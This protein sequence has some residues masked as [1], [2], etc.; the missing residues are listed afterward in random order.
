MSGM[1]IEQ[2]YVGFLGRPASLWELNSWQSADDTPHT[3][4]AV[5]D[6]L[7]QSFE[8]QQ[9]VSQGNA[10]LVTQ[11]YNNLFGRAPEAA[12]LTFWKD[13]LDKGA[14][15]PADMVESFISGATGTDATAMRDKVIAAQA[16]TATQ[17]LRSEIATVD[18]LGNN[19]KAWLGAVT[20]NASLNTAFDSL[21][22]TVTSDVSNLVPIPAGHHMAAKVGTGLVEELYVGFFG[23]PADRAGL[24]YWEKTMDSDGGVAAMR[25]AFQSSAEFQSLVA[26]KS[27]VQI[28]NSLYQQMFGHDGD[29][30]GL[31]Y[32]S[33]ALAA[34][35]VTVGTL[36]E[37]LAAGATGSDAD[38]LRA[39][40]V[41]ATSYTSMLAIQ[42]D[43]MTLLPVPPAQSGH[44]FLLPVTDDASLNTALDNLYEAVQGPLVIQPAG[45]SHA[46]VL[47]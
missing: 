41:A 26:G 45:V 13:A 30:A 9:I 7:A 46:P 19:G 34:H 4:V 16:F 15:T 29:A 1:Q 40:I 28:V 35:T 44:D 47:Y 38:A 39:K 23:R 22:E 36:V 14:V 6:A 27:D 24:E 32:W 3:A 18:S 43:I 12:G 31:V 11:V 8:F 37:S 33:D 21:Y 42:G 20:D 17:D 5:R 25:Q 2:L 10:Y